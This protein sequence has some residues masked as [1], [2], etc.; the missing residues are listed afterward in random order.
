MIEA[1]DYH[2]LQSEH[3]AITA[4]LPYAVWQERDG[5][6]EMLDIILNAARASGM[7][8]FMW[9]HIK[10]FVTTLLS[11]ASPRAIILVS[12]HIRWHW[13]TD[14][15]DLVQW[16]AETASTIQYTDEIAQSVVDT[17]LQIASEIQLVRY[18]P[19][20]L[21]VWLTERPSLPPICWGRSFGTRPHVVRVVQE[22]KD[23]EVLKSYL[24]LVW[25][26]WDT[27]YGLD[28]MRT[29]IWE[30]FGGVGMGHHRGDL[31]QRLDC[32]HGQLDRGLKYFKQHGPGFDEDDLRVR[33]EEYEKLREALE[34]TNSK[35]I[36]R[37]SRSTIMPPRVL[38]PT[39]VHTGSRATYICALPPLH[40]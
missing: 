18:I 17:L 32:V 6:P 4:L 14:R 37:T 9:C 20:D 12:P 38:I 35:A 22:L 26:E 34:E 19:V 11:K 30:D 5:K 8:G 39:L 23:I 21:W 10:R 25:S 27:P 16:W 28:E 31:I 40:L 33:K 13:F 7:L 36:G 2:S 29:S 15:G 24:L 3:K 1:E